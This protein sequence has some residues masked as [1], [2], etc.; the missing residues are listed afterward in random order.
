MFGFCT[1]ICSEGHSTSASSTSSQQKRNDKAAAPVVVASSKKS[2]ATSASATQIADDVKFDKFATAPAGAINL[3]KGS[4]STHLP[5]RSVA[6]AP[7]PAKVPVPSA[8]TLIQ[9]QLKAQLNERALEMERLRQEGNRRRDLVMEL[10]RDAFQKGQDMSKLRE[11]LKQMLTDA[12]LANE[13]GGPL[14]GNEAI[15]KLREELSAREAEEADLKKR[16]ESLRETVMEQQRQIECKGEVTMEIACQISKRRAEQGRNPLD[17]VSPSMS[18]AKGCSEDQ[19]AKE[20]E[21]LDE[22][23]AQ[24]VEKAE[25]A[26]KEEKA[27]GEASAENESSPA[28]NSPAEQAEGLVFNHW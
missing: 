18:N 21:C 23:S 28:A 8:D 15:D 2:S 26:G 14:P 19:T 1:A 3:K 11:S 4:S 13:L 9:E 17:Q 24:N 16:L 20:P 22:G 25:D 7:T 27:T 10:E 6:M 5:V 12:N